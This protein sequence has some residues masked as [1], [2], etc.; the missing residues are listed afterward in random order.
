ME[1]KKT[2]GRESERG[3]GEKARIKAKTLRPRADGT[4]DQTELCC[5]SICHRH[6]LVHVTLHTQAYTGTHARTCGAWQVQRTN[7]RARDHFPFGNQ[8]GVDCANYFARG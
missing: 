2:N 6:I 7:M 1:L 4:D 3:G 5:I 8:G